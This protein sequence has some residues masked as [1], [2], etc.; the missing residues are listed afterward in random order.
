RSAVWRCRESAQMLAAAAGPNAAAGAV[1]ADPVTSGPRVRSAGWLPE[2]ELEALVVRAVGGP[3]VRLLAR[4]GRL[5]AE[6]PDGADRRVQVGDGVHE[7]RA[8]VRGAAVQAGQGC[9]ALHL[10]AP[11]DGAGPEPPAEH[12][13]EE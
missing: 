10:P 9:G 13:L 2:A 12:R 7:R 3:S 4:L 1:V 6:R 8:R 11:R 5:P